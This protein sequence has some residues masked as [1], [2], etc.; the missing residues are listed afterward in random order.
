MEHQNK[1]D[2]KL[3]ALKKYEDYLETVT[4]AYPDQYT[5]LSEILFRY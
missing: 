1:L 3:V 5:E 2:R 4:K